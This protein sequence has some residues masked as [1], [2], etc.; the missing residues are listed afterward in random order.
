M[1]SNYIDFVEAMSEANAR[2][3]TVETLVLSKESM[4]EFMTDGNFTED[5]EE[6]HDDLGEF[7]VPVE[8]G[9]TDA[10]VTTSGERITL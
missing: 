9:D 8:T 4:Q 6:K 2:G 3:L 5:V 10:L 7:E 1:T